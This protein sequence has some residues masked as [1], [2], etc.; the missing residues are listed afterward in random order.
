MQYYGKMVKVF[1]T[2]AMYALSGL[3]LLEIL[4]TGMSCQ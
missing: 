4:Q 2:M 1:I 3:C